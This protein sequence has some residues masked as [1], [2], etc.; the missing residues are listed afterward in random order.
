MRPSRAA[1]A[2][3]G[4][5]PRVERAPEP[6]PPR[7]QVSSSPAFLMIR[8]ASIHVLADSSTVLPLSPRRP[9][10][11]APLLLLPSRSA[12]HLAPSRSSAS[13]SG[14]CGRSSSSGGIDSR[15]KS[16]AA[17]TPRPGRRPSRNSRPWAPQSSSMAIT[18]STFPTT[19]RALSAANAPMLT[20]SSLLAEVGMLSTQAGW[21]RVLFSE[22]RAAAVTWAIM[23]PL[24]SPPCSVRNAG[25][26]SEVLGSIMHSTRRSEM[27]A[28]LRPG[29]SPGCPWPGRWAD[30][31]S[32]LP[33]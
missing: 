30:R 12:N 28:E 15:M 20:K 14:V 22:T 23:R 8:S 10:P 6:A 19:S 21:A 31:G 5:C 17:A 3:S 9:A 11:A 33:R 29:P 18:R 16:C 4:I 1:T 2:P 7:A 26:W 25:R 24:L 27:L 13:M 32:C